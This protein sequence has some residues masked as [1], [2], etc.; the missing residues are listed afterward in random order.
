MT[1]EVLIVDDD[2][3]FCDSLVWLLETADITAKTFHSAE[4][5]LQFYQ[6]GP[7]CVLLDVRMPGMNGIALQQKLLEMNAPLSVIIVTGHANVPIA[8]HAMKQKAI[9]LVEKP[10]D[11]ETL[12]LAI[13]SALRLSQARHDAFERTNVIQSDW[14]RLT[15]REKQI[16]ALVVQGMAN[17][18][19]ADQFGISIKTVE[20]HRSRVMDKMQADG[21]ADL[22]TKSAAISPAGE[23]FGD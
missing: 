20:I 1:D 21:L 19:I 11:D 7:G 13:R 22:I 12:L 16:M 8:V 18:Q 23:P 17:R 2:V 3:D 15:R 14:K 9:D 6:G 4:A 5:F 10:F